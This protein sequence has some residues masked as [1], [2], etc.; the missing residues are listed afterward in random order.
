M[1]RPPPGEQGGALPATYA[2]LW[3][4]D[5]DRQNAAYDE[6]MAATG[7]AVPWAD[8][9]WDDVV[10]HLSDDDNHNRAIAGQLLCNLAAHEPPTGS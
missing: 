7:T 2:D 4:T 8:E 3:G 6:F 10:R 5:R 9:A 1:N